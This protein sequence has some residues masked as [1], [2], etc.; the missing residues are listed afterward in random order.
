MN[1]LFFYTLTYSE[2][3]N[4]T[5]LQGFREETVNSYYYKSLPFFLPMKAIYFIWLF[6]HSI[7]LLWVHIF[8]NLQY[9]LLNPYK[10]LKTSPFYMANKRAGQNISQKQELIGCGFSSVNQL[11]QL[12]THIMDFH[13]QN[14]LFQIKQFLTPKFLFSL[15]AI[16]FLILIKTMSK[17]TLDY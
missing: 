7:S 12:R 6:K 5:G 8:Q 1:I 16:S 13:A 10:R 4:T 17:G 3:Q 11:V 9:L 15:E 14:T 2:F